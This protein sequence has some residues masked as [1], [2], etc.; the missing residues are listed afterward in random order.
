VGFERGFKS[1]ANRIALKIREQMGL[2]AE[3]PIDPIGVCALY[4]ITLMRLSELGSDCAVLEGADTSFFS[5]VTVP[6]GV[7]RAIVY[8]DFHHPHRQRSSICHEL[9]HCFL[10]HECTPPL[11]PKG[12]RAY[13]GGLEAEANFLGGALLISNEAAIRIALAGTH[14]ETVQAVYGVSLD[15]IEYRLRMSGAHI[16]ARRSRR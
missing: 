11:T 4:D 12:E 5:A 15:M 10:G 16:I 9:A 3:S 8:N 6:R 2:A 7:H 14:P 1:K 13:S